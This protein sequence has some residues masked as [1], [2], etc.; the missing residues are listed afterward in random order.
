LAAKVTIT[1]EQETRVKRR[2]KKKASGKLHSMAHKTSR[3]GRTRIRK[4]EL[5]PIAY[6]F[7]P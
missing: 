5:K 3:K 4:E 2:S 1:T 6:N 7:L